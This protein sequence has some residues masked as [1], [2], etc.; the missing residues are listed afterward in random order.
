MSRPLLSYQVERTLRQIILKDLVGVRAEV[1]VESEA[2]VLDL[3]SRTEQLVDCTKQQLLSGELKCQPLII[4]TEAYARY[5]G[6][7]EFPDQPRQAYLRSAEKIERL[8]Y[9]RLSRFF[10]EK[11]I[12][13]VTDLLEQR[14]AG[15]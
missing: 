12:L 8:L 10:Q 7:A 9:W 11:E 1:E 15:C 2:Q 3:K 13:A 14:A 4:L 6:W 5:W